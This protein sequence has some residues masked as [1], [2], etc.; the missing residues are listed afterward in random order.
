V[1]L[2]VTAGAIE[3]DGEGPVPDE[4]LRRVAGWGGVSDGR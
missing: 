4:V 2:S 1:P 3:P